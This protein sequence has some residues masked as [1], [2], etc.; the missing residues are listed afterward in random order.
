M[1]EPPVGLEALCTGYRNGLPFNVCQSGAIQPATAN[2]A[3]QA[4]RDSH[5]VCRLREQLEAWTAREIPWVRSYLGALERGAPTGECT[6]P[7]TESSTVRAGE[8]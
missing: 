8:L 1:K 5:R 2:T 4:D 6:A 3:G 7:A